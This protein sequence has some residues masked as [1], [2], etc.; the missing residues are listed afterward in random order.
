[1]HWH[2]NKRKQQIRAKTRTCTTSSNPVSVSVSYK[3]LKEV[4]RK[5]LAEYD[6]RRSGSM[7]GKCSWYGREAHRHEALVPATRIVHIE[8]LRFTATLSAQRPNT[9][10]QTTKGAQRPISHGEARVEIHP[11]PATVPGFAALTKPPLSRGSRGSPPR[12]ATDEILLNVIR[13][14]NEEVS[15]VKK[16]RGSRHCV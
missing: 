14:L 3:C 8:C 16:R 10:P 9:K 5:G 13:K 1:M 2:A 4:A 7:N 15:A 6:F 11:V 12:E